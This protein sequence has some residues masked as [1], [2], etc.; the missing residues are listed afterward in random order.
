MVYPP[1]YYQ[2]NGQTCFNTFSASQLAF[3]YL[4]A[5]F[6]NVRTGILVKSIHSSPS[7]P[8]YLASAEHA[9]PVCRLS[10]FLIWRPINI[11]LLLTACPDFPGLT[12]FD[13]LSLCL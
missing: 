11:R 13:Y 10:D 8:F 3:F 1:R 9:L 4:T 2:I 12:S 7:S 5:A 6:S